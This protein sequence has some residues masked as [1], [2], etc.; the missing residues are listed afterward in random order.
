[1]TTGDS[2]ELVIESEETM[3]W[4]VVYPTTGGDPLCVQDCATGPDCDGGAS[5]HDELYDS[6]LECCR[7]HLWW[8]ADSRCPL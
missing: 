1:V 3:Q 7:Q 4:Y 6:Y 2:T 5:F 8:V